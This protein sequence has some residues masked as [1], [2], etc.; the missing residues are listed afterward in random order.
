MP[1]ANRIR[2]R[3]RKS[4]LH[5]LK[6]QGALVFTS[7]SLAIVGFLLAYTS[8]GGFRAAQVSEPQA[9]SANSPLPSSEQGPETN[10][11]QPYIEALLNFPFAPITQPSTDKL[12]IP[13]SAPSPS[14][15]SVG[16]AALVTTLPNET[17]AS[18]RNP[19]VSNGQILGLFSSGSGERSSRR[20]NFASQERSPTVPMFAIDASNRLNA[21][22][23]TEAGLNPLQAAI[24]Q[25]QSLESD[26]SL[27]TAGMSESSTAPIRSTASPAI[28][29]IAPTAAT[30][31]APPSQPVSPNQSGLNSTTSEPAPVP[32]LA[33]PATMDAPTP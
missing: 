3:S 31:T 23:P 2:T 25:N 1:Y 8:L 26:R 6:Q 20:A 27:G 33:V 19:F 16:N 28:P 32:V 18:S 29:A 14:A 17:V 30:G 21:S 10:P 24:Q 7:A 15:V 12:P 11:S 13:S 9:F 5:T 4:R 22:S